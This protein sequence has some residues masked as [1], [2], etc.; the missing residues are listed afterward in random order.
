M[1][2]ERVLSAVLRVF[3]ILFAAGPALGFLLFPAEFRWAPHHPPYERM[4]IAIYIGLGVCLWRAA[5]DPARHVLLIDFT[6]LSSLLHGG[7]MLLDSL[8][9]KGEHAHLWGDIP[10]LF[11]A[12]A[13]LWWLRPSES[14]DRPGDP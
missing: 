10:L 12:A 9:Q 7:V 6:I 2:R 13:L 1:D 14:G 8:L 3:A 5:A 4:I 11:V